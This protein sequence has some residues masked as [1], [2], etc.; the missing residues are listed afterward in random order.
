MNQVF[1]LPLYLGPKQWDSIEDKT[2]L[3]E[4]D[5][6]YEEHSDSFR[7]ANYLNFKDLILRAYSS[8]EGCMASTPLGSTRI[9][10]KRLE[11]FISYILPYLSNAQ[12]MSCKSILDIGG[13]EGGFLKELAANIGAVYQECSI[14]EP[15]DQAASLTKIGVQHFRSLADANSKKKTYNIAILSGVLEH[16]EEPLAFLEETRELLSDRCVGIVTVPS[17]NYMEQVGSLE[18]THQHLHYFSKFSLHNLLSSAQLVPLVITS[19]PAN[20]EL[21]AVFSTDARC[22]PCKK[23]SKNWT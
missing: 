12:T 2:Q 7:V 13:G 5:I 8:E 19:T 14:I 4:L 1:R 6:F 23:P 11:C 22:V 21:I 9:S 15:G 18:L 10:K 16:V 20:N 17:L 3:L